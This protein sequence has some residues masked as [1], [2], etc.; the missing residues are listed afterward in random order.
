MELKG[1]S[2]SS[3][4]EYDY[5]KNNSSEDYAGK[6]IESQYD[7]IPADRSHKINMEISNPYLIDPNMIKND[8]NEIYY[9]MYSIDDPEQIQKEV[10]LAYNPIEDH[11]K[12][13]PEEIK[14][15]ISFK[16][17]SS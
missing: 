13:N 6:L 15:L 11:G 16:S 4:S 8:E 9:L 12:I 14:T 1:E 10:K 5:K 3:S 17:T 7:Y 2:D